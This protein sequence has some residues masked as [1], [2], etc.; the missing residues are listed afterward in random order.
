[1]EVLL[2]NV[3]NDVTSYQNFIQK[4]KNIQKQDLR[5]QIPNLS[6]AIDT[7]VNRLTELENK[8]NL[9]L[10]QD[11]EDDLKK[12][13][14]YEHLNN[15]KIT[16]NFLKLAKSGGSIA[17]LTDIQHNGQPF[18][19]S[20]TRRDYIFNYYRNLY[21]NNNVRDRTTIEEFLGPDILAKAQV[22]NSK[23]PENTSNDLENELSLLELDRAISECNTNTAAGVDGIH[24]AFLKKYW[25]YFWNPLKKYASYCFQEGRLTEN[26]KTASIKLIPK[27]GDTSEIKNW[28][29]IS[30]LN[31]SYKII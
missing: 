19:D 1:M 22:R 23:I 5:T 18:P 2:N 30:L 16:T 28:H 25:Q 31:C 4:T 15:E 12:Y 21:T 7:N 27:K 13:R 24:Y 11:L 20:S 10:D 6:Q 14:I 17:D 3:W 9:I 8:L 29:P 26:F